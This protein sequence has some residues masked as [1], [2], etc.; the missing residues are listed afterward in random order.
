MAYPYGPPNYGQPGYG[1]PGYGYGPSK[2]GGGTAIT[3]GILA[4]LHG[5]LLA[6][7]SVGATVSTIQDAQRGAGS[8][9]A[10]IAALVA[11]IGI[12]LMFLVGSVLLLCRRRMGR[13]L[14]IAATTLAIVAFTVAM[15]VSA[16]VGDGWKRSDLLAVVVML[17]IAY[18]IELLILCLAVASPTARWIAARGA[19][20]PPAWPQYPYY[21]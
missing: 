15:L 10:E 14:V 9:P 7:A 4:L 18:A 17:A 6:L 16:M 12:T 19:G 13:I 2:P 3:A 11:L 20:R 8:L 5:G 21:S 1:Q